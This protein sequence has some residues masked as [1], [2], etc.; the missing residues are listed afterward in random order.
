VLG[1]PEVLT[2]ERMAREYVAAGAAGRVRTGPVEHR[3]LTAWRS[4]A[5]LAPDHA[6][7]TV[8]WRQYLDA[9]AH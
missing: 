9:H 1:G 6:D 5:Q 7:G 8:T 4:G 3:L 2:V